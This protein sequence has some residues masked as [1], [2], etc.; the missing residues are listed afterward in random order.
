MTTK[1]YGKHFHTIFFKINVTYFY[2][3]EYM[4]VCVW[5]GVFY[6]VWLF[7]TPWT[8]AHQAPLSMGFHRQEYWSGL[9]FPSPGDL[10]DPGIKPTSLDLP[11]LAGR[12][13]ST[14][15]P[16]KPQMCVFHHLNNGLLKRQAT[17]CLLPCYQASGLFQ[18]WSW[19][20]PQTFQSSPFQRIAG[21][22]HVSTS[23][24]VCLYSSWFQGANFNTAFQHCLQSLLHV[25][26][27]VHIF[28]LLGTLA[29]RE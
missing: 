18:K 1:F 17:T 19:Y 5:V 4:C 22:F 14:A 24:A 15:P 6:C 21:C 29:I 23:G 12:S 9:P 11:P 27:N 3:T 28:P 26:M 25:M 20:L 8:A 13:L 16:R 2:T 7:V 10:P